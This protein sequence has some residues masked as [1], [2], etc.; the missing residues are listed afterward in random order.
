MTVRAR[1]YGGMLHLIGN[2]RPA[3]DE[4]EV[5]LVEIDRARSDASHRHQFAWVREAWLNLPEGMAGEPWA[6][7]PET[8]RKHALIATGY[9]ATVIIDCGN[10]TAARR[11]RDALV[12]AEARAAG[13]ALGHVRGPV[14]TIWT[15]ESQSFRAMGAKRFQ[16]SKEAI[17]QWIAQKIGVSPEQL[18]Q[19]A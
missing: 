4:G 12:A 5:V 19:A 14:V 13:Y 2:N 11:V 17:L 1:H 9:C 10:T 16:E 6:E 8:L 3:L 18:R 7:T 15:P